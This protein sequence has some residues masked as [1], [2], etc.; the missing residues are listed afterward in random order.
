MVVNPNSH[1]PL[2]WV[3]GPF[4]ARTRFTVSANTQLVLVRTAV[5][6]VQ[7]EQSVFQKPT[8]IHTG[9]AS[10]TQ[11]Q[12]VTQPLASEE[13]SSASRK[14]FITP[15]MVAG[16]CKAAPRRFS[17]N[18]MLRKNKYVYNVRKVSQDLVKLLMQQMQGSNADLEDFELKGKTCS[19]IRRELRKS[20]VDAL[21]SH[22]AFEKEIGTDGR[23]RADDL[24]GMVAAF[25][26]LDKIDWDA[27]PVDPGINCELW[28]A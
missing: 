18:K 14:R 5:S 27:E 17:V 1:V 28:K 13:F 24:E 4:W 19:P 20:L 23:P 12:E 8:L 9:D 10:T 11:S 26:G 21:K 15:R 22:A 7:R 3:R 25:P 6:R 2:V 16:V